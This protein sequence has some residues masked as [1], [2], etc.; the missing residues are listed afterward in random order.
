MAPP[1]VEHRYFGFVE[2]GLVAFA[3][4]IWC[5]QPDWGW[6]VLPLAFLPW[7]LRALAGRLRLSVSAFEPLVLIFLLA[8]VLGARTAYNSAPATTKFWLFL[9][10][11]LIFYALRCQPTT[12][13]WPIAGLLATLA[14]VM[15]GCFLMTGDWQQY[16]GKLEVFQRAGIWWMGVR[17]SVSPGA[18]QPNTA[19]GMIVITLP[20]LLAWTARAWQAGRRRMVATLTLGSLVCVIA[21]VMASS[22]GAVLA[23]AAALMAASLWAL[24]L[25]A[26]PTATAKRPRTLAMAMVGLLALGLSL[27]SAAYPSLFP[28]MSRA[29]DL[30][31]A[32]GR[33]DVA[34]AGWELA[35]DFPFSGGGLA[36]F[37]G[38]YAQYILV[39][40][41]YVLGYAHN[42]FLD[43]AVELGGLGLAAV[44]GIY[45]LSAWRL[46][47]PGRAAWSRL[48]TW[49]ALTS[50]LA[51]VIH[52]QVD[53]VVGY[54]RNAV[55][56]FV[57]P[58]IALAIAGA[59]DHGTAAV[60]PV[61]RAPR[62]AGRR[63]LLGSGIILAVLLL[64]TVAATRQ[65]WLAVWQANLGAIQM[66]QVDLANFPSGQWDD[67][68]DIARLLPAEERFI[69]ALGHDPGN[70]TANHRLGLIDLLRRDFPAACAYLEAA[71]AADSRHRGIQK[72][73]GYCYVWSG[74]EERAA[75]LLAAIPEAR[76]ELEVYGGWWNEQGRP[77]LAERARQ[78]A[79]QLRT[80]A[81]R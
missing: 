21:L 9:G 36:S 7:A 60:L 59:H 5:W 38:L 6:R 45:I 51:L 1:I 42:L 66:A 3:S 10:A 17:P 30:I 37:P 16:P 29:G 77:D 61:A 78:A 46:V 65:T 68:R 27:G 63:A 67:G 47:R 43:I 50:W 72:S 70:R 11:I 24:L 12:N 25:G 56:L 40:P 13:V 44:V 71:Y 64:T 58:G 32:T 15:A 34:L 53:N 80:G 75:G 26:S 76:Q 79:Q 23:L 41:V 22:R 49:A 55:L 39:V 20:F 57:V 35:R 14:V 28:L 62:A 73:L 48:L 69:A 33:P 19:A 74:Q 4:A 81:A 18:I 2:L 31:T 54:Q 52:G 8:A